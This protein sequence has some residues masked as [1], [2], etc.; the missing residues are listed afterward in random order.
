MRFI[1]QTWFNLDLVMGWDIWAVLRDGL[2]VR[3]K[4]LSH[5]IAPGQFA[6]AQ[7]HFE[8]LLINR[9]LIIKLQETFSIEIFA[10]CDC[11]DN[12]GQRVWATCVIDG[13]DR[14]KRAFTWPLTRNWKFGDSIFLLIFNRKLLRTGSP[15]LKLHAKLFN[16]LRAL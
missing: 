6:E 7:D 11:I 13:P 3:F 8:G 9:L 2:T 15:S 12:N 14:T 5:Q 10:S 16:V 4:A 1:A